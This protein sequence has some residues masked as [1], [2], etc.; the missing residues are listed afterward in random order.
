MRT[1]RDPFSDDLYAEAGAVYVPLAHRLTMQYAREFNLV[2]DPVET[3]ELPRCAYIRGQRILV[4]RDLPPSWPLPLTEEEK[5]LGLAGMAQKY[6]LA[7]LDEQKATL[8]DANGLDWPPPPLLHLDD[9][10]FAELM[11]RRGASAAAVEL[12]SYGYLNELGDRTG[13]FSALSQVRDFLVN[14][15]LGTR[16]HIRGG[17]DRLTSA[18]AQRLKERVHYAAVLAR[19]EQSAD[20]VRL[21]IRRPSG[22]H[23][24]ECDRAILTLPFRVLRDIPVDPPFTDGKSRAIRELEGTSVTRIYLQARRRIWL[25]QGMSGAGTTDLP[26]MQFWDATDGQPGPRGIMHA[27]LAGKNARTAAALAPNERIEFAL[28]HFEKIFPGMRELFES[29]T[30]YSFDN[31][32]WARG[33]YVF[34]R[35][36]QMRA[37]LPHIAS[38]QAHSLR[39]RAYLREHRMD[40]GSLLVGAPRGARSARHLT[41]PSS[42]ATPSAA[43]LLADQLARLMQNPPLIAGSRSN[44]MGGGRCRG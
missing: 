4:R 17:T 31:D 27:Y 33:D 23:V 7:V 35:P 16:F 38:A 36:G 40:A 20:R 19:I 8:G 10:S 30:S 34:F 29:G 12:L 28:G 43:D 5:R 3:P 39:G 24:I 14:A 13:T 18:S 37:L 9:I 25:E 1:L 42:T 21:T 32:P 2:L 6:Y 44:D 11:R 22:Q 41:P 26:L 15:E